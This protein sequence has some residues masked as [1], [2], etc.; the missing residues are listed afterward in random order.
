MINATL[1]YL[2]WVAGVSLIAGLCSFAFNFWWSLYALSTLEEHDYT[3]IT[4]TP[5]NDLHHIKSLC[6]QHGISYKFIYFAR[7]CGRFFNRK[8]VF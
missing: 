1:Y 5:F 4:C 2:A 7:F 8:E 3:T 6:E